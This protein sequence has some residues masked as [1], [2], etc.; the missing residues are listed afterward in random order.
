MM[1]NLKFIENII[2]LGENHGF[3]GVAVPGGF[4]WVSDRVKSVRDVFAGKS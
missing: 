3:L 4:G 2:I 1:K